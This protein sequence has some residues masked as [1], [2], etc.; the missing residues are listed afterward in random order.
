MLG[1]APA[2]AAL[3]NFDSPDLVGGLYGGGDTLSQ[4]GYTLQAGDNHG[5]LSG[6]VGLIANGN[7]PTTCWWGGCPV[8]NTSLFYMG[9]NDGSV[10][11]TR[12]SGLNFSLRGLDFS[13]VAPTGG[14][15]DVPHGQLQLTGNLANG[16][17]INLAL[18]FPAGDSD[19]NPLFDKAMLPDA[20]R[21]A[22]LTSLKIGA[23]AFDG[24]GGCIL[25][26]D[27]DP[28]MYTAQFAI[29][30][31]SLAEVPEP[32]SL[33]LIGLGMGALLSR[34]RKSVASSNNA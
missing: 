24:L 31:L 22:E 21:N 2:T 8:N 28:L 12:S 10:T 5:G 23:C 30:N 3:L 20:F 14:Q 15:A 33:A 11:V 13:F 18:D 19:G 17:T 32:G 16:S 25:P 9:L 34:R 7:D 29:D 6:A 26:P 4:N 27:G 1:S